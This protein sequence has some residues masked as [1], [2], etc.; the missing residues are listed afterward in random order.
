MVI[1]DILSHLSQIK[2]VDVSKSH[3]LQKIDIK[4][5]S[6]LKA[7]KKLE[8]KFDKKYLNFP[9]RKLEKFE[10]MDCILGENSTPMM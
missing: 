7:C 8:G 10:I 3:T 1:I 6:S 9:S 2:L 5:S 4:Y